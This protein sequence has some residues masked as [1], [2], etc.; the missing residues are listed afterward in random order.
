MLILS[1]SACI[2]GMARKCK[3]PSI[4]KSASSSSAV[5]KN[6]DTRLVRSTQNGQNG[7]TVGYAQIAKNDWLIV[8]NGSLDDDGHNVL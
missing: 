8:E 3:K 5:F 6:R 1:I 4:A 7:N 2:F